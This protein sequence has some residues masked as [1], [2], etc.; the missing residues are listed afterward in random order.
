[1]RTSA[2]L[3]N[4]EGRGRSRERTHGPMYFGF[5]SADRSERDRH[6]IE[7]VGTRAWHN[8]ADAR[9]RSRLSTAACSI[10]HAFTYGSRPVEGEMP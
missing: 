1:M 7:R 8:A 2:R 5:V 3:K 4:D 9:P 6:G 10:M